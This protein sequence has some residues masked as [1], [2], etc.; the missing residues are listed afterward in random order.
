MSGIELEALRRLARH[1]T[2]AHHVAGRV[3]LRL[4]PPALPR[5]GELPKGVLHALPG[6]AAVRINPAAGSVV[7]EYDPAV[8]EPGLWE[9]VV[10]GDDA[11]LAWVAQALR[12]A[13][14]IQ[15]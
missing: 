10:R 14:A 2:V 3:R 12:A 4:S 1:L 11:A 6:V 9:R 5:L 8:I 13:A 15:P 7:V